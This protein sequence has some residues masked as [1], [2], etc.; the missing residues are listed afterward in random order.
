VIE[1]VKKFFNDHE[2]ES[3]TLNMC[4]HHLKEKLRLKI[5]LSSMSRAIKMANMSRKRLSGKV[6]GKQS[7]EKLKT[8]FESY[9]RIVKDDTIL[10]LST[11]EMYASEKVIPTHVYSEIGKKAFL[12]KRVAAS[13]GGWKQRSLIQSIGSDGSQYHEIV[14]G[15]V[16]RVRFVEYIE[17]LPYPPGTVILLD[18][19]TTHKSIEH[20]FK[21][22]GF[23]PLFLPPYSPEF[24]PVEFAFSIVKRE[25]RLSYPWTNGIENSID[26]AVHKMLTPLKIKQF[27]KH[28]S[29][30]IKEMMAKM[31]WSS[32]ASNP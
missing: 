7:D 6:L 24:Q 2:N 29:S 20:V 15:G 19:C 22:K 1:E 11:D 13:S 21:K 18:N 28:T 31:N 17:N 3:K 27:F 23:I 5:S 12:T 30:N 32:N 9:Q 14:Q 26:C 16:K 4:R 8:F 10:V 25:F